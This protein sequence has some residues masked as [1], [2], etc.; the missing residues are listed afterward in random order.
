MLLF[1]PSQVILVAWITCCPS[2]H[3]TS[4]CWSA[5]AGLAGPLRLP[6]QKSPP[7]L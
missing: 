5:R 6:A 4:T 2:P 7:G 3:L 1:I